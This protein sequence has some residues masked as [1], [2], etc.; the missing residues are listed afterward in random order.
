ME[1]RG[2]EGDERPLTQVMIDTTERGDNDTVHHEILL[3]KE[4][5]WR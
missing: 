5:G 1:E 3:W 2:G 4:K